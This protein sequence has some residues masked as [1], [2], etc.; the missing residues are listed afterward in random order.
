LG[1]S[2][3]DIPEAPNVRTRALTLILALAALA[4]AAA[5]E[6][7]TTRAASPVPSPDADM[8]TDSGGPAGLAGSWFDGTISSIQVYDRDTG[9]FADPNGEGFYFIFEPDGTYRE[10]AVISNTQGICSMR[11]VG[12]NQGTWSAD[13]TSV[14]L[15]Q[16]GGS[17]SITNTCGD[18]GTYA[19]P[20]KQTTYA[21]SVGP[22]DYGTETLSLTSADGSPYGR[23]HRWGD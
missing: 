12:E 18:S 5:T 10:G 22:D 4:P 6:T 3:A 17:I 13:A 2:S 16:A 1:Q 11:L 9:V 19:Q 21:W 14:V 23:F 20:S 8:V 15:D 7:A